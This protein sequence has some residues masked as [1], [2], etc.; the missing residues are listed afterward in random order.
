MKKRLIPLTVTLIGAGFLFAGAA[1]ASANTLVNFQVDLSQAIASGIFDPSTQTIAAHGTFNNWAAFNLTNN[2]TGDNPAV[3]SGT[4]DVPANGSVMMYKYTIEPGATY[5][6]VYGAGGHNRLANLP[7]TSGS[8]LTLPLVYWADTPP[9]PSDV[10]VTFQVNLAQQINVGAFNPSTSTVYARGIF[11]NWSTDLPLTNDPSILTTN[12]YGLVSSNVYVGTA[13][14]SGSPG[15]TAYYKFYIDTNDKWESPAPGVGDPSDANNNRFFNLAAG[16]N[17]TLPIIYFNDSP[18]SPVVNSDVTFQVDMTAQAMAGTFDP[19]QG[20]V[21]EVRGNFNGWG[22]TPVFATNNPAAANTNLYSAVVR[23]SDGVGASQ[24]YKF[25]A[26]GTPNGGWETGDNRTFQLANANAQ[27]LPAVYFSGLAPGDVLAQ[28]TTVTFRVDMTG[29]VGTDGHAF[30][31]ASDTVWLNGL[32]LVNGSP[33]FVSDWASLGPEFMLTN[34]PVGSHIYSLDVLLPK[35]TTPLQIAYKYGINQ[36][37]NE[38]PQ[39]VNHVRYVRSTGAYT[40]PL[41][42]FGAMVVEP[43]FTNLTA[44]ASTPGHMLVS[45]LGRPGV[46]LQTRTDLSSGS[47]VDHPETDGLSSTN[48][49]TTGGSLFFRLVQ[50]RVP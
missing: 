1:K 46:H 43:S 18:Y 42:T 20:A 39:G 31:P 15:E 36:A 38:A 8:T 33:T 16:P 9:V 12:Q 14:I 21:V 11:N 27:T 29:A 4:F 22:A 30:D 40:M 45:W 26:T 10:N 48:W 3:Y 17:Q 7:A 28:D 13:T 35:G 24:Q 50:Q 5:E 44:T 19:S 6:A 34:N 25:W 32:Q 47:W 2:P 37:D 41:D 23:F 49:P